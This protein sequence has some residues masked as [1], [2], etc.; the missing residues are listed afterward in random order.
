MRRENRSERFSVGLAP[1]VLE[2]LDDYAIQH[3]WTR[4]QAVAVLV[5]EGLARARDSGDRD[6][7]EESR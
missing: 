2:K 4:S 6:Q 5:E 3:H 7:G 1:S